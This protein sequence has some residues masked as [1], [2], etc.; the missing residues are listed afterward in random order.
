MGFLTP[1]IDPATMV[2]TPAPNTAM[3]IGA[4]NDNAKQRIID[5]DQ[6]G[7]DCRQKLNRAHDKLEAFNSIVDQVNAKAGVKAP[8]IPK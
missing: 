6:A 3:P 1:P 5:I 8:K 7:E 2:C 4:T